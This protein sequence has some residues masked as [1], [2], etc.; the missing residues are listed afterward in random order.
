MCD[1][2]PLQ[3]LLGRE[4]EIL[5]FT[6]VVGR[7]PAAGEPWYEIKNNPA[8]GDGTVPANSA[9][10]GFAGVLNQ[11]GSAVLVEI[12]AGRAI[13][14]TDIVHDTLS[15]KAILDLLATSSGRTAERATSA[16]RTSSTSRGSST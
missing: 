13:A 16:R 6:N 3:P 14:H 9:A 1:P 5:P 2:G 15:Q 4:N 7:L 11:D 8:G 12:P 10:G